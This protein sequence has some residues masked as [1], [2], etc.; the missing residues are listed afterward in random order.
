M[1]INLKKIKS[2]RDQDYNLSDLS[3]CNV[4][5]KEMKKEAVEMINSKENAKTYYEKDNITKKIIEHLDVLS[6]ME[7]FAKE[8]KK[9]VVYRNEK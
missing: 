6:S 2:W 7:L 4:V 3:K 5:I 1:K 9:V 8:L